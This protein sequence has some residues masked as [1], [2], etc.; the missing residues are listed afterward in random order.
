ME[1]ITAK[2]MQVELEFGDGS[3][4]KLTEADAQAWLKRVELKYSD[5]HVRK[6]IGSDVHTWF[7]ILDSIT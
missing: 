1:P 6:L 4:Y 2:L 7:K 3:V 5:G